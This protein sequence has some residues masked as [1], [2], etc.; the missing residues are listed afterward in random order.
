MI[1]DK[2]DFENFLNEFRS[3]NRGDQFSKEGF[4]KIDKHYENMHGALMFDMIEIC[5]SWIE[6]SEDEAI[7]LMGE[8][9]DKLNVIYKLDNGNVLFK[10]Y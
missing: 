3:A 2:V 1:I 6:C 4:K 7:D 5:C 9:L 10:A 8:N